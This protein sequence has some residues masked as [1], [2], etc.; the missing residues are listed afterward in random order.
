M[1]NRR[2]NQ[3]IVAATVVVCA[4]SG[5]G[6]PSNA[7]DGGDDSLERAQRAEQRT[8][9]GVA[10]TETRLTELSA[11]ANRLKLTAAQAEAESITA[12]QELSTS[13]S[14][15]VEAQEAANA[16]EANLAQARRRIGRLARE[17]YREGSS[18]LKGARLVGGTKTAAEAYK[19]AR[20]YRILANKTN[21]DVSAFENARANAVTLQKAAD[22]KAKE[23][24]AKASQAQ[25]A[26]AEA[27]QASTKARSEVE[28]IAQER[29][30]LVSRLAAQKGVTA[31]LVK[32]Q[33][34]Q[35]EAAAESKAEAERQAV[36][37]AAQKKVEAE[38]QAEARK[39]AEVQA[40]AQ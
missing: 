29:N 22:Q 6:A 11:K 12:Q 26:V 23:E 36:V 32:Q 38:A 18:P 14:K 24:S 10:A 8:A 27:S 40:E 4:A 25:Q 3:G 5:L 21:R 34:E 17:S 33:R 15:A 28:S 19:R 7:D 1:R 13:I 35:K 30:A 37:V 2:I 9:S 31:E 39:Q 20:A 16:A